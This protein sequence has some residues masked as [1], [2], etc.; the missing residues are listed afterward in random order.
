MAPRHEPSSFPER[1]IDVPESDTESGVAQ[2]L[3]RK[4]EF[5]NSK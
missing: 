5:G 4:M 2:G 1:R 3:T